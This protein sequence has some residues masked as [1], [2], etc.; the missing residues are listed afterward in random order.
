MVVDHR[1]GGAERAAPLAPNLDRDTNS[2]AA[3]DRSPHSSVPWS[4]LSR[5]LGGSESSPC[6]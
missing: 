3:M 4:T 6:R 1:Q 2:I 5:V